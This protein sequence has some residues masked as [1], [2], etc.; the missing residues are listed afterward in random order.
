MIEREDLDIIEKYF[1]KPMKE[2]KTNQIIC[3]NDNKNIEGL[4]KRN[5]NIE[6]KLEDLT[7][8]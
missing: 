5:W 8:D 6:G 2:G 4:I 1:L 3:G 7:L